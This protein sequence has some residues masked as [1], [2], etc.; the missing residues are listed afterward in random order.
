MALP[1]QRGE[2]GAVVRLVL[3]L[4][5]VRSHLSGPLQVTGEVLA[6][7]RAGGPLVHP[8]LVFA[9]APSVEPDFVLLLAVAG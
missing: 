5:V 1:R 8:P 6:W 9:Q 2:L 4:D 7:L 3:Y